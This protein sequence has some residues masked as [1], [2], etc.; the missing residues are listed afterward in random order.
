MSAVAKLECEM[1][2][3]V[4]VVVPG[5][6]LGTAF[7]VQ[8]DII[9]WDGDAGDGLWITATNWTG[10]PDNTAPAAG[11]TV[12]ISNGDTVSGNGLPSGTLPNGVAVNLTGG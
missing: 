4:Q 10:T 8:A 3:Q 11:D 6:F 5:L 1:R 9:T 7:P 12:N 2:R